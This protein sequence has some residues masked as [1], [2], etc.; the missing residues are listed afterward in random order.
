MNLLRRRSSEAARAVQAQATDNVVKSVLDDFDQRVSE[1]LRTPG[2]DPEYVAL[3]STWNRAVLGRVASAAMLPGRNRGSL[4]SV[5]AFYG[6]AESAL[7]SIYERVVCVDLEDFLVNPPKNV[8][9]IK[10][11]IDSGD[12]NLPDEQYDCIMFVEML[13]H[14]MWS[15]LPLLTWMRNH[16][17][18]LFITTP[19]AAEW[20]ALEIHPWSRMQHFSAI[21][22]AAPGQRGNP[23]PMQHVKQYAVAEFVELLSSTGWRIDL[24]DRVGSGGHQVLLACTQAP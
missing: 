14:L 10:S 15:P 19:D 24:L 4:L 20:P 17:R 7:A 23:H 6:F 2:I 5:G 21:P 13:E 8:Q 1:G 16:G 3:Q 9:F 22:G 18:S 12:W 11:D